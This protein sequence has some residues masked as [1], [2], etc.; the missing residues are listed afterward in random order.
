MTDIDYPPTR[1]LAFGDALDAVEADLE[2]ADDDAETAA[3]ESQQDA[4]SWAVE[5]W[6]S[7]ETVTLA[8]YTAT[9][10]AQ[11]IDQFNTTTAGAGA[12]ELNIWLVAAGLDAAP[13]LDDQDIALKAVATGQLP[14]A[15]I[16][17]MRD[18]LDDLNALS[19]GN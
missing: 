13:W 14:P 19:E 7:D 5:Q 1:T 11:T 10:R 17:W 8:A 16:D 2:D 6:G 18:E 4:L 9:T 3:T 12:E 15:L